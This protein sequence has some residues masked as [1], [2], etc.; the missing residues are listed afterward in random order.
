MR[1]AMVVYASESEIPP[2][3]SASGNDAC[4]DPKSR[5]P[6]APLTR[7]PRSEEKHPQTTSPLHP[8]FHDDFAQLLRPHARE[9]KKK[10]LTPADPAKEVQVQYPSE[11]EMRTRNPP[12]PLVTHHT[13]A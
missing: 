2:G 5:V 3:V 12:Q 4:D 10:I 13:L 9:N 11:R 6:S 8:P 7:R 1:D